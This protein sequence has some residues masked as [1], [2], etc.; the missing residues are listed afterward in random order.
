M[1][2]AGAAHGIVIGSTYEVHSSNLIAYL[3]HPNPS[4]GVLVVFKVDAFASELL[5][6]SGATVFRLPR[7][8]NCRLKTRAV[9]KL[10]LYSEDRDWLDVVFFL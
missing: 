10:M 1:L 7:L 5:Y 4:L 9:D 8:F 6:A 3:E 2:Y